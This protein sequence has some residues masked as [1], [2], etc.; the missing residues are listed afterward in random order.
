MLLD[1]MTAFPRAMF[2]DSE[3]EVTRWFASKLGVSNLPTVK[4]VK[5]HRPRVLN[6]AGAP[7]GM[8]FHANHAIAGDERPHS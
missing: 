3:L 7:L 8:D 1:V 2:G 5:D 4:Q 6:A